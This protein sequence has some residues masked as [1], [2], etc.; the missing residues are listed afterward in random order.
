MGNSILSSGVSLE[1]EFEAASE[2]YPGD[3]VE[4]DTSACP[5]IK[6]GQDDATK[7]IGVA[8]VSMGSSSGRGAQKTVAY[9]AGDQVKVISG[10]IIVWLRLKA[11]ADI[12]CGDHLQSGGSGEVKEY[13]CATD[14]ACQLLAQSLETKSVNTQVFQWVRAKWLKG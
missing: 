13:L 12:T 4:F 9:A 3:V 1:M 7:I 11:S 8:D 14:E 10:P 6:A 2:I 5:K